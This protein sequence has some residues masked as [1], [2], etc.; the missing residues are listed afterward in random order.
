[1]VLLNE[2]EYEK[3]II[4][5]LAKNTNLANRQSGFILIDMYTLLLDNILNQIN[6]N[7]Y[8][9]KDLHKKKMII[10]IILG[11]TEEHS[12]ILDDLW[13]KFRGKLSHNHQYFPDK[14]E[15][16]EYL[17]HYKDIKQEL[18]ARIA[19]IN[20]MLNEQVSFEVFFQYL[21]DARLNILKSRIKHLTNY[22][23]L[24]SLVIP[25]PLFDKTLADL[26][27]GGS[28]TF[29]A[30]LIYERLLASIY[31]TYTDYNI[32]HKISAELKRITSDLSN[33]YVEIYEC[34]NCRE[35][36]ICKEKDNTPG[37]RESTFYWCKNC[38]KESKI[39]ELVYYDDFKSTD[40]PAHIPEKFKENMIRVT[41][42]DDNN[43][44]Y[45]I[46]TK[47]NAIVRPGGIVFVDMPGP[48]IRMDIIQQYCLL[49]LHIDS[50]D[51]LD[52]NEYAYRHRSFLQT[53]EGK[54]LLKEKITNSEFGK[55]PICESP[56][57]PVGRRNK[58]YM[59]S[60][61]LVCPCTYKVFT[62]ISEVDGAIYG[63]WFDTKDPEFN[64][65]NEL[66][67]NCSKHDDDE[68]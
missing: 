52:W 31:E 33:S 61:Y 13:N 59:A 14:S 30:L 8:L 54:E 53:E 46:W 19:I 12:K 38:E 66:K 44:I 26:K 42:I 68:K 37:F 67:K 49:E 15:I 9:K 63:W 23:D 55:C 36:Y 47:S 29:K 39:G 21:F 28:P 50:I 17:N 16:M 22:D 45:K 57:I 43:L 3:S 41:G 11:F 25:I 5:G 18:E 51:D 4:D 34:N 65:I 48:D 2:K 6:M 10:E 1:M 7:E 64:W 62:N 58:P 35:G 56:L 20:N 24:P 32:G 40:F 27:Q 60:L